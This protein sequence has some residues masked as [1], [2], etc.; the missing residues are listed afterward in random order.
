MKLSAYA[1]KMG[2]SY[3]TAWNWWKAGQLPGTQMP[4]GTIVIEEPTIPSV[5][6]ERVAV[7]ARVSSTE[8]RSN[9][10]SQAERLIAYC[11][12]RG[13]RIE[14]VV[15]EVGSGINESRPKFLKLLGDPAV[16]VIVVEHQD[17]AT[18]F[19]FRY[20]ETTLQQQGRRI[21]IV[22]LADNGQEELMADLVAI[23]YAFSARLYGPRRAKRKTEQIIK[24]LTE[25]ESRPEREESA[26]ATGGTTPDRSP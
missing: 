1:K 23:V 6:S 10:A 3:R 5:P 17:R 9:L 21:E 8:N 19:G 12:A 25:P 4:S 24:T 11:T 13:Y 7:Y 22:N 14:Q 2:V 16:T 18:R 20:L 15:K 26:D